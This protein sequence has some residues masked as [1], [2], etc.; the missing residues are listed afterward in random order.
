MTSPKIILL[1]DDEP[2]IGES[3]KEL[4]EP[5]LKLFCSYSGESGVSE[6]RSVNPD[7]ILLDIQM[8]G[9]DG[10]ETLKQLRA[11]REPKHIPIIMLTENFL[12]EKK[13]A[14]FGLG[15]DDYVVKPFHT[16]ELIARIDSKFKTHSQSPQKQKIINCGNLE[17]NH[18]SFT[19]K[20]D[21][22]DISVTKKEFQ[23]LWYFCN[24]LDVVIPR[25]K[26]LDNLWKKENVTPRAV[27]KK[28]LVLRKKIENCNYEI[29]SL[30]SAGYSFKAKEN[31]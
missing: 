21:G 6:A 9:L 2:E 23:M 20:I 10:I 30:Y 7:L 3:L 26:L 14:A 12:L 17:L 29:K 8:P 25:T 24:H 1:I 15:A 31:S 16:E 18:D 19:A 22:Q 4:F 11:Q 27:D 28:I 5:N 13:L